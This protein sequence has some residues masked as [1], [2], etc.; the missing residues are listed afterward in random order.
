MRPRLV[1]RGRAATR[2]I[3]STNAGAG[4]V[5]D[6]L[7]VGRLGQLGKSSSGSVRRWNFAGP[8]TTSTS[9]CV[10][11]YSSETVVLRAASGRRRAAAGRGR[12]RRP[13]ASTSASSA[14]RMP[15]SM[16]VAWSST[17]PSSA[18]IRTPESVWMAL[19]VETPRRRRPS[20][21]E[22]RVH[23]KPR[24]S[25]DLSSLEEEVGAVEMWMSRWISA[26]RAGIAAL[27]ACGRGCGFSQ[28]A[29]GHRPRA[30]LRRG[31]SHSQRGLGSR[32]EPCRR[33]CEAC[34]TV[35]WLRPPN[36]GRSRGGSGR[37]ARARG[38]WRPGG[39]RRR[40]AGGRGPGARRG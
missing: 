25:M 9:C 27:R 8:E 17:L 6:V 1:A 5:D 14:T 12:R 3:V 19:R 4:T 34:R 32:C 21:C 22:E 23:G 40:A 36:R 35:E 33:C 29:V 2:P 16:S 28:Q 38:T 13:R 11:R 31:S 37:S 18:L 15:S 39:R 30:K 10:G 26:R 24:T 7:G 20:S